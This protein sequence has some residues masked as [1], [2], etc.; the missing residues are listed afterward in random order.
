MFQQFL[1]LFHF[2]ANACGTTTGFLP[3]LY[4]NIPCDASGVPDI[5]T[6]AQVVVI[7]ANVTRILIALS[8]SLAIIVILVAAI[9]YITSTGDPGRVK[10]AKDIL[11]NVITGLVLIVMAY[12]VVTFI[13]G[14]L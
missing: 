10:R 8:G 5:Q 9:Y 3:S 1:I 12:A 4:D 2:A 11:I 7:V 6:V 13:S 14:Q